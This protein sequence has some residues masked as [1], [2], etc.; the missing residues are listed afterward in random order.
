MNDRGGRCSI[1]TRRWSRARYNVKDARICS[2]L[3][4]SRL[5]ADRL[6]F[7]KRL[8]ISPEPWNSDGCEQIP[9]S[10]AL[11]QR[12]NEL[13]NLWPNLTFLKLT[14]DDLSRGTIGSK[15]LECLNHNKTKSST[16]DLFVSSTVLG[17]VVAHPLFIFLT[18][19]EEM[20]VV[21]YSPSLLSPGVVCSLKW[22]HSVET[23]QT[24]SGRWQ[25][26]TRTLHPYWERRAW[27]S[28]KAH[29]IIT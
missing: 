25:P 7:I 10:V 20:S 27:H 28:N 19:L 26:R 13:W 14:D 21:N 29:H 11:Y 17:V 5:R 15:E 22:M 8:T 9:A 6:A 12:E 4:V 1:L 24:R 16:Y 18:G 3:W 2:Q 23:D